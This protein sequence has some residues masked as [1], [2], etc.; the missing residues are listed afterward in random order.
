MKVIISET[1]KHANNHKIRSV[2][3]PQRQTSFVLRFAMIPCP[4]LS[5]VPHLR[6]AY[7]FTHTAAFL[8]IYIYTHTRAFIYN[9]KKWKSFSTFPHYSC[10]CSGKTMELPK[11][12]VFRLNACSGNKSKKRNSGSNLFA[13]FDSTVVRRSAVLN[14]FV[15]VDVSNF[16][17]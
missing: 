7:I 6:Y 9:G 15:A 17:V 14:D 5:P 13:F 1:G 12:Y 8:F 3:P 10:F 2:F 11:M 4:L 16:N